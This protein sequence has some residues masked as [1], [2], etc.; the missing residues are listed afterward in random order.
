MLSL[1][2]SFGELLVAKGWLSA[3]QLE[4]V[5][6]LQKSSGASLE[7]VLARPG[8]LPE[9][10]L[11]LALAAHQIG[12]DFEHVRDIV[13]QPEALARLPVKFANH[14]KVLPLRY[15]GRVLCVA[16]SDPRYA[17]VIDG[18]ALV[19]GCRVNPVMASEKEVLEALRVHYGLGADAVDRMMTGR[20]EQEDRLSVEA[21]DAD[22]SEAS[23]SRFF[24]QML[25]QAHNDRASDIHIE[26]FED[27]LRIR[28]R[29]D[30]VLRDANAPENLRYFRDILIS[31]IKIMANLNIAEKRL[32]QDGRIYVQIEGRD[33]DLRVSF[34]P[35]PLGESVVIRI[36]NAVRLYSLEELGF[37]GQE[38]VWLKN[39]LARPH[40]IIFVTGPT[41]SGKTTTLYACLAAVNAESN[42]IITV[43]D[44]VEAQIKGITQVQ[45]NTGI[46]LTFAATLRSMLRHD[47]DMLMVGEVRDRETAQITIQSA[48]TGHLVFSTLHTNDAPSSVARLL[49]MGVEPFLIAS[50][51]QTV[52]AQRLVR[53]LC[54]LCRVA[55]PVSPQI[56]REFALSKEECQ[57]G[58]YEARGCKSCRMS[59]YDGRLAIAEFLM[60]NDELGGLIMQRASAAELRQLALQRG[61][62][63]LR[64]NG[65]EKVRAGLTSAQEVLR[66]IQ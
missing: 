7:D 63:T 1:Q 31:R 23:I 17:E 18:V 56:E 66:V 61:M 32:P 13:P 21:I 40:G 5:L 22:G 36:L 6:V 60:M 62:K 42:K 29:I 26:S 28:Y 64:S 12:V 19:A 16:M 55:V 2:R 34:L 11:S 15:D 25:L 33:M 38:L 49:D 27:E 24:N 54:P 37:T 8:M 50:A 47:P 9:E 43:E 53:R 39:A 20:E 30:G 57:S 41:G 59:G 44:P 46:G 35:T 52:I 51:V 45:T 48:L 10:S 3:E 14:F 4:Q 65:W 58:I